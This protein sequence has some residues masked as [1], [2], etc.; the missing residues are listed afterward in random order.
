[1][2]YP[3]HRDSRVAGGLVLFHD[4]TY[5]E[6][7]SMQIWRSAL[8]HVVTQVFLIILI[9]FFVDPVDD[10]RSTITKVAKWMKDLGT[11][12]LSRF[13]SRR[14]KFSRTVVHRSSRIW[15]KN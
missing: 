6:A 12:R 14:G 13:R 8:W 9:A 15:A 2:H 10:C 7:Q 4:A 11:A 5:I 1:M 3:L